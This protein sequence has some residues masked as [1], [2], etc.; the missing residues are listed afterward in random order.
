MPA[1][2]RAGSARTLE[3]SFPVTALT[4]EGGPTALL[5]VGNKLI[6]RPVAGHT[7]DGETCSSGNIYFITVY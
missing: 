1:L 3:G 6:L 7:I 4:S 5:G 2:L